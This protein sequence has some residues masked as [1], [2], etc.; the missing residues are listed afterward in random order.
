MTK[1][2]AEMRSASGG[3]RGFRGVPSSKPVALSTCQRF[4]PRECRDSSL[5]G[6]PPNLL[7]LPPRMGGRGLKSEDVG[8]FP[9]DKQEI[10]RFDGVLT[11]SQALSHALPHGSARCYN[12]AGEVI[13]VAIMR[14][15]RAIKKAVLAFHR[16]FMKYSGMTMI[17]DNVEERRRWRQNEDRPEE[18]TGSSCE[19][20]S[21][22]E[23]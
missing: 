20:D 18:D 17:I 23:E 10:D 3:C 1:W 14:D 15:L 7:G 16:W 6:V 21:P 8:T 11:G 13:R 4:V 2:A 12:Q 22:S 19:R 9:H 5:P